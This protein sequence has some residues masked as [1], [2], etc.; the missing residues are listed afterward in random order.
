M[1]DTF[2]KVRHFGK[3]GLVAFGHLVSGAHVSIRVTGC[4][5]TL[6]GD[7][8]SGQESAAA[9]QRQ[10][11]A[12]NKL[13]SGLSG[14]NLRWTGPNVCSARKGW[15]RYGFGFLYSFFAKVGL[16]GNQED[17]LTHFW[18]TP[19]LRQGHMGA[20]VLSWSPTRHQF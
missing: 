1:G 13:L 11:D 9:M 6:R 18:D 16:R 7:P 20:W 14:E 5:S 12:A 10:M 3:R 4:D 8:R 2:T 17:S 15:G 19:N